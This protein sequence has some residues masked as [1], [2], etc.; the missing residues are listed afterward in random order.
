MAHADDS[1]KPFRKLP[2]QAR[3]AD[4]LAIALV[5]DLGTQALTLVDV[6][7]PHC[8][9]VRARSYDVIPQVQHA[10]NDATSFLLEEV[11]VRPEVPVVRHPEEGAPRHE[12]EDPDRLVQTANTSTLPRQSTNGFHRVHVD[13]IRE[14]QLPLGAR[15]SN[16]PKP[17]G[18]VV[19]AAE[20]LV[21]AVRQHLVHKVQVPRELLVH[22]E[23][24]LHIP[25]PD[26]VVHAGR[27]D[28][29]R[30]G[31]TVLFQAWMGLRGVGV[32]CLV[33]RRLLQRR[34]WHLPTTSA[35]DEFMP[36]LVPL[37]RQRFEARIH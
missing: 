20:D 33:A 8:A 19:A 9:V 17:A 12:A 13:P 37:R 31:D 1:G 11:P 24:F 36:L 26:E 4:I 3:L 10:P 30:L 14:K 6:P 34:V 27:D 35:P 16:L 7:E 32:L 23:A 18:V 15:L 29:I 25:G 22:L 28:N 5:A 21:P 2:A